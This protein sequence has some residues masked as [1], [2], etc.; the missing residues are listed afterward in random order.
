MERIMI[1]SLRKARTYD[2]EPG[3][4]PASKA[5]SGS[6]PSDVGSNPTASAMINH[7]WEPLFVSEVCNK[8]R[9]SETENSDCIDQET[10]VKLGGVLCKTCKMRPHWNLIDNVI[11]CETCKY[12][13]PISSS[14]YNALLWNKR[15]EL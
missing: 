3:N 11:E 7:D 13:V 8:T 9:N 10:E 6:N 4:V 15:N 12:A 5:E 14:G 1:S 2:R